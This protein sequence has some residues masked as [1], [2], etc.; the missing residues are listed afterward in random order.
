MVVYVSLYVCGGRGRGL[1]MCRR[2][3]VF[4]NFYINITWATVYLIHRNLPQ[5]TNRI[6]PKTSANVKSDNLPI[7]MSDCLH[8]D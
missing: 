3:F 1:C 8:V 4:I 7:Y 6:K 5:G 2:V